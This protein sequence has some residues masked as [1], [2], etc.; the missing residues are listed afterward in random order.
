MHMHHNPSTHSLDGQTP[1]QRRTRGLDWQICPSRKSYVETKALKS[2]DSTQ[3]I[4]FNSQTH[5]LILITSTG[6][7]NSTGY[8]T[9]LLV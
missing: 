3:S 7:A 4:N 2:I 9:L 5:T 8:A 1:S 6:K